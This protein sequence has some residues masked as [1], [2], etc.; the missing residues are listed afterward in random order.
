MNAK[1]KGIGP[2]SRMMDITFPMSISKPVMSTIMIPLTITKL[3][4]VGIERIRFNTCE[5]SRVFLGYINLPLEP[6]IAS[7]R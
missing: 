1:A 4:K 5:I 2:A 7:V 6:M 3:M